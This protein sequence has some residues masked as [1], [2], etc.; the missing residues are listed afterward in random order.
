MSQFITPLT[1]PDLEVLVDSI[2]ASRKEIAA[3]L[4]V[5][6]RT[7]NGWIDR[8]VA[9][10]LAGVALFMESEYGRRTMDCELVNKAELMSGLA[11]CLKRDAATLRTRIERLERVGDFGSAN[12]P[13]YQKA[14]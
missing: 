5:T 10:R 14:R 8:G 13:V 9:P 1:I 12:A 3:H 11:E 2:C 4:G 7:L 6:V